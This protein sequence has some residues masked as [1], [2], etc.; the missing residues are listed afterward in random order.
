[1]KVL[2]WLDD[3]F[4]EK[5]LSIILWA[6]VIVM[7]VQVVARYVFNSSISWSE[8]LLR[9]LFIWLAFLGMSYCVKKECHM[10]IDIIE[11]LVPKTKKIFG[12]IGDI[13][14]LIFATYMI[15]PGF[16]VIEKLKASGQISPAAGLPMYIVYSVLLF[17]FI[18][19][20][21]RILQKNIKIFMK[22]GAHQ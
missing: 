2:K 13:S 8:E 21:V 22:K 18:L 5:L 7:G 16:T 19:V 10:R 20:V 6:M 11:Q 17:G 12:F 9:Y 1:M 4:E 14:F 15:R 3:N